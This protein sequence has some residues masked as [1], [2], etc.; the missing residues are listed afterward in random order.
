M[1]LSW[2]KSRDYNR[3]GLGS[4]PTCTILLCPWKRHFTVLSAAWWSWQTSSK[5]Q[6]YFYKTKKTL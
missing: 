5:F 1:L 2:L 3:H 6:S 4:K